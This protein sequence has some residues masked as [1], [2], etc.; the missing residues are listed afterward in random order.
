MRDVFVFRAVPQTVNAFSNDDR[1]LADHSVI[2][3]S[4]NDTTLVC[5]NA[6]SADDPVKG[7]GNFSYKLTPALLKL[8]QEQTQLLI[9]AATRHF[10]AMMGGNGNSPEN[11]KTH[12]YEY[13][14][15]QKKNAFSHKSRQ[16]DDVPLP[17]PKPEETNIDQATDNTH[18]HLLRCIDEAKLKLQQA[19]P[20]DLE[21][22]DSERYAQYK[23]D[24]ITKTSR[25]FN[26][27]T[28]FRPDKL[29]TDLGSLFKFQKF[30]GFDV[31]NDSPYLTIDG[32][33]TRFINMMNENKIIF[34]NEGLRKAPLLAGY[35]YLNTKL[36]EKSSSAYFGVVYDDTVFEITEQ[37]SPTNT[38]KSLTFRAG[39]TVSNDVPHDEYVVYHI[40][41]KRKH[42]SPLKVCLIHLP[43][44]KA[45][46]QTN[47]ERVL[48]FLALHEQ[49]DVV[50]G[51]TNVVDQQWSK[52]VKPAEWQMTQAD[53]SIKKTRL[54]DLMRNDQYVF[55]NGETEE[56]DG[57]FI[58]VNCRAAWLQ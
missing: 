21:W 32:F 13:T 27:K 17:K 53:F 38:L 20:D 22:F 28:G 55:K 24:T 12:L 57:M 58:A 52:I 37:R 36:G 4:I 43:S 10:Y 19:L 41:D 34:I 7:V 31:P 51:D 47:V 25:Y 6:A 29:Y 18:V 2:Q 40:R 39:G 14:L 49:L 15:E 26:E 1:V 54:D 8:F 16:G 42:N 23:N 33:K 11:F 9:D 45:A 30:G 48:N 5:V 56:S 35:T 3:T 50:M 46:K 44:N